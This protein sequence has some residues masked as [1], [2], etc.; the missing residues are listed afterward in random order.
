MQR[1]GYDYDGTNHNC[2][3][4]YAEISGDRN[5]SRCRERLS[6][7]MFYG[8][9]YYR[10][11]FPE[12]K[13]WKRDL[14]HM[15]ALGFTCVKHWAVWNWIEKEPGSFD[16]SELDELVRLSGEAG[17]EVIINIIPEGAPYW[18]YEGHEQSFYRTA[19]GQSVEPGGPANIPSGGW[20]GRCMDDPEFAG[21]TARFIRETAR[22]FKDEVAVTVIDVWNEPHLEPMYDYRSNIL[23]YCGHSRREFVQW[24]LKKYTTLERLNQAWFR[25]YS[26]WNQVSPPPRFGTW[27]DMND[28]RLFWLENVRRWLNIRVKAA[29]EGAPDKKVQTHVAYSGILGNR[30]V[31][32]LAGELGD[33]FLLA[34]EV[35]YF[36]L[37]SFPKWLM[38]EQHAYRHL[39]HNEMIA[40]AAH[41]KLFYQVELQGGGGKPGLLGGEV[42]DAAD[43]RIWN[44]NTVAAGGK[45]SVYWQYAPEPAGIESPGFG[46]TGFLGEDT[47]R[48]LA[49]RKMAEKLNHPRLDEAVLV[50][51]LNAVYVSRKSD[52]LCY[53]SEK[54]E[55][56]YAGSLS[57]VYKA[58]YESGIAVRFLH[59]DYIEELL[60]GTIRF[61]YLPMTLVLS[62]R[63]RK[64]MEYFV[65]RGG[66][67]VS[68]ACPGLYGS[69]G[70]LDQQ[71]VVLNDLFGLG[72]KEIQAL[73]QWGEVTAKWTDTAYDTG[74]F[75]GRF[76]RQ[77][78]SLGSDTQT[79]AEFA[80]GE[81]AV[82]VRRFGKGQAIW[83]GTYPSYQYEHLEGEDEA[84]RR[85]L[86]RWMAP[87]GYTAIKKVVMPEIQRGKVTLAPYIR[88]LETEQEYILCAVNHMRRAT[89]VIVELEGKAAGQY[90][91]KLGAADGA[92]SRWRK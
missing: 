16:F 44:W 38:G 21:L 35:D 85:L 41:G 48:S 15:K 91:L 56:M 40:A 29:R 59:E 78:V 77:L 53:S 60:D 8:A 83:I 82:T 68:E 50:P 81:P 62:E 64:V 10:P 43:I 24:L 90:V 88:L 1:C 30:I 11:P 79:V 42:P 31:G 87:G 27:T 47:Q 5:D 65:E 13:V 39:I 7:R 70:L 20:P 23:C 19:D 14:Y 55:E 61:L 75:T 6:E 46:L 57:G 69:D 4:L 9:Q 2:W 26:D 80:D 52:V 71:S 76:Y 37:S 22:H 63:E 72:H 45:G 51:A 32:G 73:P 49:A 86:T 89:E 33:E 28:W 67:L 84:T 3:F 58:A 34:R 74:T 66:I 36:G 17:L 92:F 12:K 18:V 54:R 25:T